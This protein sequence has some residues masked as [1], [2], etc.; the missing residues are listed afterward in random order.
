MK[1]ELPKSYRKQESQ[2]KGKFQPRMP[3]SKK[4]EAEFG[5]GKIDII[6]CKE[7]GAVYYYK[8]WHSKLETYKELKEIKPLKFTVCPACQMIKDKKY[9]G[10][11]ILENVPE[12]IREDIKNLAENFG[13]R[14]QERDPLDRII[15]IEEIKVKRPTAQ[16]KRKAVSREEF[17]GLID[18][19]ILFTENQLAQR[20]AKKLN[21][22]FSKKLKVL[23]SHSHQ[24]DIVRIKITF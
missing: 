7:C 24:E 2:I 17:K 23:I 16:R 19:R 11:I 22:T 8:N 5:P 14:A 3:K 13:K 10:E 15:S 9:E 20:L 4:E 12:N 6:I 21:E 18:I 1:K